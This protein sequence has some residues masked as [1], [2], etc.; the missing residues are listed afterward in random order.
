MGK[1]ILMIAFFFPPVGGGG[2]QRTVKF[3]KY[4]C[5]KGWD[6]SILSA[7]TNDTFDRD[8]ELMQDIPDSSVITRSQFISFTPFIDFFHR[9]KL[10]QI[11]NCLGSWILPDLQVGWFF[12]AR[13]KAIEIINDF[14][15]DIIYTTSS[16][17]TA[18][19]IGLSIKRKFPNIKWVADFRDPWSLNAIMYNFLGESRRKID[20]KIEKKILT[21][22]DH[23]IVTTESNRIDLLRKF[24]LPTQKVSTITNGYDEDDFTDVSVVN[25]KESKPFVVTYIGEAYSTYNP[26]VF[27][28][29]MYTLIGEHNFSIQFQFVGNSSKWVRGFLQNGSYSTDFDKYFS[30][31][32]YVPHQQIPEYLLGSNLLFLQLPSN[33]K[34]ILPGKIFEYI[35][36]GVPILAEVPKEGETAKLVKT[37]C[38]GKVVQT[39]DVAGIINVL[40]RFYDDWSKDRNNFSP[41]KIEIKKYRRDVLTDKLI[42]ILEQ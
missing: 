12:P 32:D 9:M 26:G 11:G 8:P 18:H 2:V 1:K 42:D 5:Q 23:I 13:F 7:E 3:V 33:A 41:N 17:V 20:S 15:P 35:R 30:L 37:S 39:G 27:I 10:G 36:S 21:K 16:P 38:T 24:S 40:H 34:A 31:I 25:E 14:Q 4:L 28:E 29:A 22:C 19:L 6:V